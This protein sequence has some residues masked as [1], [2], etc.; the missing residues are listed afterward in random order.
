MWLFISKFKPWNDISTQIHISSGGKVGDPAIKKPAQD[1]DALWM[2]AG[3]WGDELNLW[4]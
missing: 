4:F 3:M 1:R 2:D